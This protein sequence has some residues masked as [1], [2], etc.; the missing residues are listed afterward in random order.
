MRT[1]RATKGAYAVT[2]DKS[3]HAFPATGT[4]HYRPYILSDENFEPYE[5]TRRDETSDENLEG[6]EDEHS[7]AASPTRVSRPGLLHLIIQL[8][9]ES[10]PCTC[11]Q[12]I[13]PLPKG[14]GGGGNA[15]QNFRHQKFCL[16]QSTK[17][18]LKAK[19]RQKQ[20]KRKEE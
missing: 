10:T 9:T 16:R 5:I 8:L 20:V 7:T 15:R 19:K 14:S 13:S 17:R 3:E 6:N 1:R 4:Y 18:L 12:A 2:V 11:I